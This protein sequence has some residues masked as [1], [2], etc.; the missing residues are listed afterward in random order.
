ML[1]L[2]ADQ[3]AKN[4]AAFALLAYRRLPLMYVRLYAEIQKHAHV[5]RAIG[6]S[7]EDRV[8]LLLSNGPEAALGFLA[9]A[10]VCGC[11]ALIP[12][13]SANELDAALSRIKPKALI[14]SPDLD[15]E[16][17][18]TVAK[19][20]ISVI[21]ASPDFEQ[22]AG[23]FTLSDSTTVRGGNDILPEPNEVALLLHT[24]GTTSQPKLVGL[25]HEHLCRSAENIA[26]ALQLSP[27]DRCLNI[28]PL[29]HIHGIAAAVLSTLGAGG[30]V[31]CSSGFRGRRFSSGYRNSSP[32]GSRPYRPRTLRSWPMPRKVASSPSAIHCA[33]FDPVRRL[34]EA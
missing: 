14:A 23:V 25:T 3:A 21:T 15:A 6:I 22:E 2:I 8:A 19:H 9:T 16:K 7:N 32:A 31:V 27:E 28:M 18:A 17:R 10:T 34:C 20:P 12:T 33:L 11:A 13:C 1:R 5:L 26:R 29:F 24:S 4:P 30:S